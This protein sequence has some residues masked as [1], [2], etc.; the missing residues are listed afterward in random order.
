MEKDFIKQD[1]FFI[2]TS[3][4]EEKEVLFVKLKNK[5]RI[6]DILNNLNVESC[7]KNLAKE[8]YENLETNTIR[9]ESKLPAVFYCILVAQE[10]LGERYGICPA[11]D[12]AVELGLEKKQCE[13]AIKKFQ[14]R[15]RDKRPLGHVDPILT[16]RSVAR[17][18]DWSASTI[19]E[20]TDEWN[21]LVTFN[22]NLIQMS[23]MKIAAGY[24]YYYIKAT[25]Y[26]VDITKFIARFKINKKQLDENEQ[27][28][29][30]AVTTR[31]DKMRA[32]AEVTNSFIPT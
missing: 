31:R 9:L 23:P 1:A 7:V 26:N 18:M 6:D 17:L 19:N 22:P 20:I 2:Q 28:I 27:I 15:L 8:H 21:S 5:G 25:G 29:I 11:I 3:T 10:D 4:V 14:G 30:D 32:A 16:I 13:S 12:L 24:I